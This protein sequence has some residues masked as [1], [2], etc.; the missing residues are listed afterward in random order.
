M[1]AMTTARP[2]DRDDRDADTERPMPAHAPIGVPLRIAAFATLLAVTTVSAYEQ[3]GPAVANAGGAATGDEKPKLVLET[4]GF[5]ARVSGIDISPDGKSLA[6]SS[7]DK[8]VRVWDLETGALR[9]TLRGFDGL[10]GDGLCQTL[11]YSPDGKFLVVGVT[12]HTP[13]GTIRVYDTTNLDRIAQLLPGHPTGGT[14]KLAFSRDGAYL[15]S[16]GADGAVIVWDWARRQPRAHMKTQGGVDYFGFPSKAPMVVAVDRQGPHFWSAIDGKD[17]FTLNQNEVQALG[18]PAAVQQ[19]VAEVGATGQ[20]LSQLKFPYGGRMT[21]N[22][23]YPDAGLVV[24][25]GQGPAGNVGHYWAGIWSTRNGALQRLYEGHSYFPTAVTLSPDR[26]LAASGDSFGQVHVWDARTGQRRHR[27]VGKGGP[28]YE[29]AFA[30]DGQRIAFGKKP[31]GADRWTFNSYADPERSFDFKTRGLLDDVGARAEK[32]PTTRG[33]RSVRLRYNS[34]TKVYTLEYSR[35]GQVVSRYTLPPGSI[36][37]C[38]GL[39]GTDRLGCQD[40]I[41]LGTQDNSIG[42]LDP[43]TMLG[44]LDLFGSQG[45][46]YAVSESTDG[47]YLA[48]ASNDR[49]IRIYNLNVGTRYA[50]ADFT[51]NTNGVINY[52][53]PNGNS[54][55]AGVAVGDKFLAMDG[56][57]VDTL[58][59]M[60]FYERNWPF[61]VGQRVTLDLSRGGQPFQ[62]QTELV[63]TGD[64]NEPLLSLFVADDGEWIVWTPQGYYDASLGGDHLIGWHVNQGRDQAAKFYTAHQFRK[65]FYRPDVIDRVLELGDVERAVEQANADRPREDQA[66]DLRDPADLKSVEP[67]TILVLEPVEGPGSGPTRSASGPRSPP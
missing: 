35:G 47:R 52:V 8:L 19:A 21:A 1:A 7:A 17:V 50:N 60:L 4:E 33:D 9:Q 6:V 36:P 31:F 58:A 45:S 44:R 39:L 13:R 23:L 20:A 61:Q 27:F 59:K 41:V 10:T 15:A 34:G 57:D 54:A 5:T 32:V 18:G 62:V 64:F 26:T 25:G 42:C 30:A 63:P 56:I 65:R 38:Y 66:L 55:R 37:T 51:T 24:I 46:V 16:L 11:V 3:P 12:D 22:Q 67:P 14:L 40:A 2:S 53:V 43:E 29:V 28:V 49:V 48:T